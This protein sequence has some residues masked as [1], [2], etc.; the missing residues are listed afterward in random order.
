MA[1]VWILP[2]F[3]I[4]FGLIFVAITFVVV[5]K[6]NK[7]GMKIDVSQNA[8]IIDVTT[9]RQFT[10]GYSM[11]IVKS[12]LPRKN[13]TILFEFYP[14]DNKQ[15]ENEPKPELQSV[16]IAKE[17]V[18]RLARGENSSRREIIKILARNPTD[19][20]EKMRVTD[21]GDWMKKEGQLAHLTKTFGLAIPAGDEAIADAMNEFAR[22]NIVRAT[23]AKMREENAEMRKLFPA[24]T[25]V[26]DSSKPKS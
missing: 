3:T 7:A 2:I 21:E 20:P 4:F 10:E 1:S 5:Y 18:K 19:I 25:Q 8:P 16:V 24:K 22:G 23:M 9:R 26:E 11:G 6:L 14:L 15:G 12:E 13:G 17:M